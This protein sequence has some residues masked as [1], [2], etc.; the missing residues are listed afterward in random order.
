MR[1]MVTLNL[2]LLRNHL[3]AAS[4]ADAVASKAGTHIRDMDERAV[5]G[6]GGENIA[7]ICAGK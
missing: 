6:L 3:P 2:A 4:G 7:S 1:K 5:S